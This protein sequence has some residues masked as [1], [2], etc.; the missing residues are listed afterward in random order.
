MFDITAQDSVA[1]GT[2][3]K[4][5][6]KRDGKASSGLLYDLEAVFVVANDADADVVDKALRGAR[7]MFDQIQGGDDTAK[8]S[9][10]PAG[11][12]GFI[13]ILAVDDGV[14]VSKAS[15]EIVDLLF[16]MAKKTW[17]YRVKLKVAGAP[18]DASHFAAYLDRTLRF[19]WE[20]AQTAIPFPQA[21]PASAVQIVTAEDG[22][23]GY[24]FGM[25]TGVDGDKILL[26][27][28]GNVSEVQA[29]D[30]VSRVI[31]SP[32]DPAQT[33]VGMLQPHQ[34]AHPKL[35]WKEIIVALTSTVQADKL[36]GVVKVDA[37]TFGD[38]FTASLEGLLAA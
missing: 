28:F 36:E 30:V 14:T 11:L 15:A 23:G 5:G 21:A 8:R 17:T 3:T 33:V 38:A 22:N 16:A 10:R 13:E 7:A 29:G 20:M 19:Q 2:L 31:L 27:D 24:V 34:D 26:D 25:Q 12:S 6:V 32:T 37:D 1:D 9:N 35:G 4:I 18:A